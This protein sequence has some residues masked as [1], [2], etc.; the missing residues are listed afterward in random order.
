M[1]ATDAL[2]LQ[3]ARTMRMTEPSTATASFRALAVD[4]LIET[5]GRSLAGSRDPFV[6]KA[7]RALAPAAGPSSI[8]GG[9]RCV[10][11]LDAAFANAAAA[12][13]FPG[14]ASSQ[15]AAVS[16]AAP[17]I[18]ALLA[19]GEARQETGAKLIDA[20]RAGLSLTAR[21]Q[22]ADVQG[23]GDT[24][25]PAQ[26][27]ALS[28]AGA[29]ALMMGLDD[30]RTARALALAVSQQPDIRPSRG[31]TA[32]ALQFGNAARNG[33]LGALLA[34]EG[35]E[36]ATALPGNMADARPGDAIEP[37][38]PQISPDLQFERFEAHAATALPS[39]NI[40]I[41]FE[42]LETIDAVPN[43]AQLGRMLRTGRPVQTSAS[44]S[45]ID[46]AMD[47]TLVETQWVP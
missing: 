43:L 18:A 27:A 6:D 40:A 42:R 44:F 2:A 8:L 34:A 10:A 45:R 37:E 26:V 21:L 31:G 25:C 47:E 28:T 22:A 33:L 4:M 41:L 29:C 11:A 24:P 3:L 35:V 39:D 30:A 15:A 38:L 13:I 23:K 32:A 7:M 16:Q 1:A 12:F 9:E 5:I 19:L 36:C 14:D 17:L 20:L 46:L